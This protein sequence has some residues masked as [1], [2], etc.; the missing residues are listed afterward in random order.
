MREVLNQVLSLRELLKVRR[1]CDTALQQGRGRHAGETVCGEGG[2]SGEWREVLLG[3]WGKGEEDGEGRDLFC[4][5]NANLG[6]GTV[7]I[8][9]YLLG[10]TQTVERVSRQAGEIADLTLGR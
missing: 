10:A 6:T 7:S 2:G 1:P 4:E 8:S 3:D 5:V 9:W